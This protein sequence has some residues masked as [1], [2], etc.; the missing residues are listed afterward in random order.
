[1]TWP[2][3]RAR[4]SPHSLTILACSS[5]KSYKFLSIFEFSINRTYFSS[6]TKNI[7]ISE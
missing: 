2:Y 6:S 1:M 3:L 7:I 5:Y 4:Y